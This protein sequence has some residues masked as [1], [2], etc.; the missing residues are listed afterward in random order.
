MKKET[1]VIELLNNFIKGKE[2]KG[3]FKVSDGTI[4]KSLEE[5]L[6]YEGLKDELYD[7]KMIL[8]SL[9]DKVEI[10]EE[11]PEPIE[12]LKLVSS[13]EF[14]TMTPEERYHVTAIEYD[15]INEINKA[16]NYLLEKEK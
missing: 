7:I 3:K 16:V 5:L 12:E 10:L 4:L 14:K 13:E 15:K 11:K 8:E 9:T 6:E 2:P 1:T